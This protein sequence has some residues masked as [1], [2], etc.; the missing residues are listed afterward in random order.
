MNSRDHV[1]LLR[2]AV[3][4]YRLEVCKM[5]NS[6]IPKPCQDIGLGELFLKKIS[7]S[8]I[9]FLFYEN[10]DNVS[11]RFSRGLHHA[12]HKYRLKTNE[13]VNSTSE[14]LFKK[15]HTFT[16]SLNNKDSDLNK[17]YFLQLV[18]IRVNRI[19][20]SNCFIKKATTRERAVRPSLINILC[21]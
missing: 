12:S 7:F 15:E 2:A 8:L 18:R 11:R 5:K 1:L 19:C 13:D 16:N 17:Y 20:T 9:T 21:D 14:Y 3:P 6:K 4:K 10:S